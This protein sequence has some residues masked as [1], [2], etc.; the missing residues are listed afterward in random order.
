MYA[1]SFWSRPYKSGAPK[2]LLKSQEDGLLG[3]L[4][5]AID[6]RVESRI[7]TARRFA[8]RVRNHA[9]MVDCYLAAYNGQKSFFGLDKKAVADEVVNNPDKFRIY[10]GLSAM[11]NISRY[12]LPDPDTYREFFALRPLYDFPTLKSTCA[13]FKGCPL[14]KLDVAI[15]YEL[16]ELVTTF[17]RKR[18]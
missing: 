12:D 5:T 9:K 2:R 11:S 8:V 16:P 13:F 3:D 15:A 6:R 4:R 10:E 17:K 7:A 14:N 18:Q 1:G